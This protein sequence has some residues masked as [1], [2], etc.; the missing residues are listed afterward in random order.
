M[1]YIVVG[2]DGSDCARTALVAA[3]EQ[4]VLIDAEVRAVNIVVPP[5]MSGYEFGPV[6]L[7]HMFEA[8]ERTVAAAIDA[9]EDEYDG[10]LPVKITSSVVSGHIGDEILQAAQQGEGAAMV[11]VGSRGYGAVK[12]FLL[13]S[14]TT[15]LAHH[16]TC[17][18]LILPDPS[19]G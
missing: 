12:S 6:H 19:D 7:E 15:Y 2:V 3:V 13:G 11:V 17:P 14:V 5:A 9:V 10:D 8:G 1:S 4:A 16:I 18:L